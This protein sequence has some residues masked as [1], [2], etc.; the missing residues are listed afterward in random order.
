VIANFRKGTA[1]AVINHGALCRVA[2]DLEPVEAAELRDTAVRAHRCVVI[3]PSLTG[4]LLG[5]RVTTPGGGIR[6]A[7]N[8]AGWTAAEISACQPLDPSKGASTS[9][10]STVGELHWRALITTMKSALQAAP[11][12]GSQ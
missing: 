11:G 3:G 6:G 4:T 12:P 1:Y 5:I 10:Q 8:F 2:T 9:H 7:E